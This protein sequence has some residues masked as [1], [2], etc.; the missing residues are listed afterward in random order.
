MFLSGIYAPDSQEVGMLGYVQVRDTGHWQTE[1]FKRMK[2]NNPQ[3]KTLAD[4]F[5]GFS[6]QHQRKNNGRIFTVYHALLSMK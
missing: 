3:S 1:L 4:N 5:S 6:T 2:D